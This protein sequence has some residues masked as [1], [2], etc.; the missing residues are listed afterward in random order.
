MEWK[1]VI[2]TGVRCIFFVSN[3]GLALVTYEEKREQ[4]PLN[5]LGEQQAI[6]VDLMM[7]IKF[8]M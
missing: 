6:A 2:S 7:I 8:D 5:R 1:I 4:R 3:T